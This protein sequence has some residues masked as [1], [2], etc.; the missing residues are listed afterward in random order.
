[1]CRHCN[2]TLLGTVFADKDDITA[3]ITS[4]LESIEKRSVKPPPPQPV[5]ERESVCVCMCVSLCLR[6]F[7]LYGKCCVT[8]VYPIV[9]CM[10]YDLF[11]LFV[12]YLINTIL[13]AICA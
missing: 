11:G 2:Q 6:A 10:D 3:K 8:C 9:N 4:R 1:M 7:Y 13:M 5:R 12:D